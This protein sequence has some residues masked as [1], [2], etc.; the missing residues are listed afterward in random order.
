M[1][2]DILKASKVKMRREEGRNG[3]WSKRNA[4]D[5]I[6]PLNLRTNNISQK[7]SLNIK[8]HALLPCNSSGWWCL[9]SGM[10]IAVLGQ[11]GLMP[12]AKSDHYAKRTACVHIAVPAYSRP[13]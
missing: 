6:R 5:E 7:K 3:G 13:L 4:V 11:K 9:G 12:I 2:C 10:M 1:D 8:S